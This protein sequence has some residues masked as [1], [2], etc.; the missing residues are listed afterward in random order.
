METEGRPAVVLL[1]A[2][3]TLKG[4]E[5]MRTRRRGPLGPGNLT[6]ALGISV[7]GN[8]VDLAGGRAS[9]ES[10]SYKY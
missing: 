1:L 4:R 6:R 9:S 7:D 2:V 8:R 5:W 10:D 3:V